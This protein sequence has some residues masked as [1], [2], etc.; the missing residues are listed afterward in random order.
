MAYRQWFQWVDTAGRTR[1]TRY[2]SPNSVQ[3]GI[4]RL[5]VQGASNGGVIFVT[6][7]VP[8]GPYTEPG[9]AVYA[10]INQSLQVFCQ[11]TDG[12]NFNVY[13]PAP[14]LSLFGSDGITAEGAIWN[15]FVAAIGP[16]LVNPASGA[17]ISSILGGIRTG[18]DSGN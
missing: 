13:V 9:A 18:Q 8:G 12:A 1:V 3:G 15:L 2:D 4:L 16:A 7:A 11:D 17:G 10:G 14:L 5:N 6:G